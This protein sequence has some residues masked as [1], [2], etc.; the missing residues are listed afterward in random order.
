MAIPVMVVASLALKILEITSQ[1]FVCVDKGPRTARKVVILTVRLWRPLL[2]GNRKLG[3]TARSA[4]ASQAQTPERARPREGLQRQT[5]AKEAFKEL[6][7]GRKPKDYRAKQPMLLI[8]RMNRI[9]KS[10]TGSSPEART[11]NTLQGSPRTVNPGNKKVQERKDLL[12]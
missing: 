12:A 3:T 10:T 5:V 11:N 2:A 1:T 9:G 6:T 4:S 7:M 8:A